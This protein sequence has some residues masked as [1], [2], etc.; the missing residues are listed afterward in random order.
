MSV[1]PSAHSS[2]FC[3]VHAFS[4]CEPYPPSNRL[5]SQKRSGEPLHRGNGVTRIMTATLVLLLGVVPTYERAASW[6]L[7]TACA[8][9]NG[10][11]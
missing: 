6:R 3:S 8:I 2:R 4:S 11:E 10:T 5:T 1:W 9:L 7:E